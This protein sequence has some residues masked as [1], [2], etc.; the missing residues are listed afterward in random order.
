M[1]AKEQSTRGTRKVMEGK[2]VSTNANK[3]ITI[4]VERLTQH[5]LYRKT[6]RI[7]KKFYVHDENNEAN[8]GD[9]VEV[10]GTRPLSK[11]KCWR[12]I[13]VTEQAPQE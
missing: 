8:V 12:L 6:I 9:K 11:T 7:R 2:V 1:T 10:M 13:R 3:T 5:A 4:E